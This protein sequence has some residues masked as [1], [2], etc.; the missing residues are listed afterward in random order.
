MRSALIAFVVYALVRGLTE[1]EPFDLLLPLWL[2]TVLPLLAAPQ[3]PQLAPTL[4]E[5]AQTL[6]T[7]ALSAC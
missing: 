1:A 6:D 3:A 7:K 2:I 5:P 4:S